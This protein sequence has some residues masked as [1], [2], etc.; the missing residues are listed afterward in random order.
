MVYMSRTLQGH[1]KHVSRSCLQLHTFKSWPTT[2]SFWNGQE[3]PSL[4]PPFPG[5]KKVPYM[6]DSSKSSPDKDR[7][8]SPSRG[9]TATT[10]LILSRKLVQRSSVCLYIMLSDSSASINV[11]KGGVNKNRCTSPSCEPWSRSC[12]ARASPSA[13]AWSSAVLANLEGTKGVPRNGGHE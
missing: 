6:A 5:L 13:S 2:I 4:G 10:C 11:W 12:A 7:C 3:S 9:P 8:T 1:F